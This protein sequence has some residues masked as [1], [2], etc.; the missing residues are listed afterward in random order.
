MRLGR[1]RPRRPQPQY[2]EDERSVAIV[3]AGAGSD[4]GLERAVGLL[5]AYDVPVSVEVFETETG[6][7]LLVREVIDEELEPPAG[8]PRSAA[9]TVEEIS[10]L[11]ES[12]VIKAAFDRIVAAAMEGGLCVRPYR[13]T[14]MVTPDHMRTRYL[15]HLKPVAGRGLEISHGTEAFAEF[16]PEPDQDDLDDLLGDGSGRVYSG[17]DLERRVELI[18]TFLT[19]L[20][21]QSTETPTGSA[22]TATVIAI[23]SLIEPGEWTTYGDITVAAIGRS[24]AA[25]AVGSIARTND[26]FPNAHRVLNASGRVPPRWQSSDGGGPEVCQRR[27]EAEGIQ[28]SG[29]GNAEAA[30]RVDGATLRGRFQASMSVD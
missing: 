6:A 23:A 13:Q 4:P 2:A 29:G 26:D 22:D 30:R 3:V 17:E 5:S 16:Y 19:G 11:G 18:E 20:S 9:R 25:M 15:M 1:G 10:A 14:V 7:K 8:Q 28:F 24:S 21:G 12:E 27:L